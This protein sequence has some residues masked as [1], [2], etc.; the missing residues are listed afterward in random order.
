MGSKYDARIFKLLAVLLL[1]SACARSSGDLSSISSVGSSCVASADE[2]L[3]NCNENLTLV[4]NDAEQSAQ[5]ASLA[6]LQLNLVAT[7]TAPIS[8]G[9]TLQA[10]DVTMNGS[11]ALVSYNVAGSTIAG[12]IDV[13]NIV[14]NLPTL[15]STTIFNDTKIHGIYQNGSNVYAAASDNTNGAVLK[16]FTLSGGTLTPVLSKPLSSFAA[17]NVTGDG[18]NLYVATGDGGGVH[19]LPVSGL[20]S[21][22]ATTPNLAIGDARGV[23]VG[24]GKL[25]TISGKVGAQPA[26]FKRL[27]TA[28][29]QEVSTDLVGANTI[30]ES[31]STVRLGSQTALV[32]LGDGGAKIICRADGVTMATIPRAVVTGVDPALTVTNA[33]AAG[34][35]VLFLANG[36][37]GAYVYTLT[38]KLFSSSPS[39]NCTQPINVNYVGSIN[40]GATMSVNNIYYNNSALFVANGL[41]G[42]KVVTLLN[43]ALLNPYLDY[44]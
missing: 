15:A 21:A 22:A 42:F 24:G 27:T 13:L 12:A 44:P 41:G 35:G 40:F 16:T 19:V 28:G 5:A 43:L 2:R 4:Q 32:S 33:A 31:K 6:L 30:A 18:T 1:L 39:A 10:S 20:N 8:S 9:V 37:A 34:P 17:V 7:V 38:N 25:F 36:V 3:Q 11:T 23:A 14:L 29:V 26:T